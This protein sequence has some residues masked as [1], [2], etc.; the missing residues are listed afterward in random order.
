MSSYDEAEK[1]L[2]RLG[3]A[4]DKLTKRIEM[5][6]IHLHLNFEELLIKYEAELEA[7]EMRGVLRLFKREAKRIRMVKKYPHL[8]SSSTTKEDEVKR[9]I[10]KGKESKYLDTKELMHKYRSIGEQR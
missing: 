3:E 8:F 5:D 9:M 2:K 4:K 1:A 6:V 10:E 7:L